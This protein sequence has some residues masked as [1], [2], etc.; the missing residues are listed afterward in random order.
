MSGPL[1]R[2]N[3]AQRTLTPPTGSLRSQSAPVGRQRGWPLEAAIAA[4]LPHPGRRPGGHG[5]TPVS[6]EQRKI[7][8]AA[9]YDLANDI[10]EA[11]D[12]A[13]QHPDIVKHL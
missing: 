1:F 4:H 7:E 11:T 13:A 5:G 8:H 3:A 12:V 10:S 6:Y 9:L 2:A